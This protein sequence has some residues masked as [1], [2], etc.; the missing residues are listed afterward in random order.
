MHSIFPSASVARQAQT[1]FRPFL[2]VQK[3]RALSR[4]DLLAW[5]IQENVWVVLC[6]GTDAYIFIPTAWYYYSRSCV[7]KAWYYHS[8]SEMAMGALEF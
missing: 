1:R 3:S 4:S 7:Q 8:R 5:S 2:G 6:L